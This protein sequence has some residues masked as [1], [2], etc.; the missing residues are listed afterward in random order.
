MPPRTLIY[1]IET[2]PVLGYG[3]PPLYETNMFHIVDDWYMLSFAYKWLGDKTI[4][5]RQKSARR[6]D[7]RALVK[8]LWKLFDEADV[9][10]AHNG[11]SFDQKKAWTRFVMHDL[12]A[13]SPYQSID[14][15]K[16]AKQKTSFTGNSLSQLAQFFELGEKGTTPKGTWL[17]CIKGDEKAWRAMKRYNLQD[18]VL[19]E[20]IWRKLAPY[21]KV[22][23]LA[24]PGVRT[25]QNLL[26]DSPRLQRRGFTTRGGN[27]HRQYK[28]VGCGVWHYEL[29]R[30]VGQMRT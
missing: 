29:L 11:D 18:V 7:D 22:R 30:N 2:S 3:Y 6:G 14:T 17:G 9:V 1:D 26:C 20:G 23:P 15:L 16:L 28:C 19:L 8:E 27:A 4:H 13:P 10:V 12:G 21:V 25:C 5:Y 24:A